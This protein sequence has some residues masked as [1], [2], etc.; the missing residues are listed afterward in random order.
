MS[1]KKWAPLSRIL[2]GDLSLINDS[3]TDFFCTNR[4]E[5]KHVD[6]AVAR[7]LPIVVRPKVQCKS[8][9]DRRIKKLSYRREAQQT[10]RTESNFVLYQYRRV[11]TDFPTTSK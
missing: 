2:G 5:N 9:N 10:C 4:F 1:Y 8:Y 7:G 3:P 11:P 6:S